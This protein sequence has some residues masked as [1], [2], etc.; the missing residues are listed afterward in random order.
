LWEKCCAEADE[1]GPE[2]V[3]EL[4]NQLLLFQ[5]YRNWTNNADGNNQLG[6]GKNSMTIPPRRIFQ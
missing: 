1:I 6:T 4:E 2:G 3:K 5:G